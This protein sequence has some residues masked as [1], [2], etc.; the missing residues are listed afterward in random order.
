MSRRIPILLIAG[1]LAAGCASKAANT[2]GVVPGDST[3]AAASRAPRTSS[4][5]L[6]AEELAKVDY[7]DLYQAVQRLRPSWLVARGG[8]SMKSSTGSV[9]VYIGDSKFGDVS[10]LKQITMTDVKEARYMSPSE[11]QQ[12]FG[13]GVR[14]GAIVVTRK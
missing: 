8:Q 14:N 7:T 3:K 5:V 10:S 11:A 12:R 6:T 13:A 1:A 2:E 9:A 4:N